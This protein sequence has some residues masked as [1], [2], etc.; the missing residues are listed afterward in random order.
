M[1]KLVFVSLCCTVSLAFAP[2]AACAADFCVSSATA[3]QT[4]LSTAQYNGQ[5]NVIMVVQ[6]TYKGNFTH[7]A[8][9][10]KSL[11]LQGGYAAGCASRVL[12]PTKTILDGN[13]AGTVLYLL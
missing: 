7:D 6:G 2:G 12:D 3:L 9:Y 11:T 13:H 10:G 8:G 5:D 4:A 1:K